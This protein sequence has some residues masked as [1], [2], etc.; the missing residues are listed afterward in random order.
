MKREDYEAFYVLMLS[1][2]GYR[3]DPV[4]VGEDEIKHFTFLAKT[5]RQLKEWASAH[6]EMAA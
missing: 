5:H 6:K 2:E 1:D 3:L 4:D